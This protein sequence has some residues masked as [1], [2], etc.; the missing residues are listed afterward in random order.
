MTIPSGADAQA[1]EYIL[2]W[3]SLYPS[4]LPDDVVVENHGTETYRQQL[5]DKINE[6][7][8]GELARLVSA[9]SLHWIFLVGL[10]AAEATKRGM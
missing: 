2:D 6:A 3:W 9:R 5:F 8:E 10:A 7:T 1:V 4:D